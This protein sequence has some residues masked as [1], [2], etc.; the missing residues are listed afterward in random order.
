MMELFT[1]YQP[2]LISLANNPWGRKFLGISHEV[3]DK[4]IG[5]TENA[6][7]IQVGRNKY[8]ATFRCYP[9][10][11]K[12]L[13]Y[14][15]TAVD[16]AQD[17]LVRNKEIY[18][19]LPDYAGLLNYAGLTRDARFPNI[20]LAS[21]E[22]FYS[23]A[24]DGSVN[25]AGGANGVTWATAHNA[26]VGVNMR[27]TEDIAYGP[28]L[29]I[30]NDNGYCQDFDRWFSPHNTA[31]LTESATIVSAVYSYM[32]HGVYDYWSTDAKSRLDLVQS[33][34]ADPTALALEDFDQLGTELG[35]TS[36][37]LTGL[38]AD[39]YINFT[40]NATGLTWISKTGW[41][42]LGS[43]EGHD[44]DNISPSKPPGET[45]YTGIY[46]YTS[47]YADTTSDP[48]LVVTYTLPSAGGAFWLPGLGIR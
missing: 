39:T 1:K 4:I 27:A 26:T 38:S 25:S 16:I 24:G 33:T 35:A 9:V 37:D 21:P 42:K 43:R 29:G 15:L 14:A 32:P 47:E 22:T 31:S 48:K 11:A 36:I 34:Q 10:F 19:P 5:L 7:F 13:H 18:R 28:L 3:K 23:G 40:L 44:T 45:K 30:R 17:W 8:Q 41:T 20:M 12:R 46:L 6:Y 2:Q